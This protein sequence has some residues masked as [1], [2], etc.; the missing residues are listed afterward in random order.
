MRLRWQVGAKELLY[1][2]LPTHEASL[3]GISPEFSNS[4]KSY[5]DT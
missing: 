2:I 4:L 5:S 1:P 3:N